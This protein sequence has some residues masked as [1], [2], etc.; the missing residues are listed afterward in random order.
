MHHYPRG[1]PL[2][3][4]LLLALIAIVLKYAR[5]KK[6]TLLDFVLFPAICVLPRLIVLLLYKMSVR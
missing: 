3:A 2:K 1:M 6:L 5:A 4:C